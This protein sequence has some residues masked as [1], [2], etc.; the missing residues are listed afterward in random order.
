MHTLLILNPGHF[1]AAL[2]LRERH[3]ILSDD[4]Y[5][6]SET[7]PDLDRFIKIA[8]S[9]NNRQDNPT[10]WKLNV[11]RGKD[12][13]EKLIDEKQGDIAVLAGRNNTKMEN[14][15]TL[16][17][18]GLAILADKPWVTTEA[19]LP[20][21]R[22]TLASDRPMAADI[23]TERYEIATLLQKEFLAEENVFGRIRVEDNAGPAVFKEC[24]HHLYK[25]VNERPLVRPV[26]Y[27]DTDIQ[28]EGIVDTTIHLVDMTQWMLFPGTPIDY[29]NDIQLIEARRWATGVPLDKFTK[30]TG[31]NQ[32]PQ[33]VR[34]YV[35][36]LEFGRTAGGRRYP[37]VSRQRHSFG[38]Y[39]TSVAGAW[40]QNRTAGRARR[41][42][43]SG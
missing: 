17:R 34:K 40:L 28:G 29:E 32:S 36:D 20:F 24:V 15:D 16:N 42:Q 5:V 19:A 23:M 35:K 25:V 12:G 14:I 26:W 30:I 11:Y 39:D 41:R 13:L 33:T 2:V 37:P 22:S 3:P 38:S 27:F 8:E 43:D 31:T 4:I 1:H 6:Y 18:S 10:R 9:F 21:L 7:G